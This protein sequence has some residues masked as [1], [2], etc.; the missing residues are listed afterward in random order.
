VASTTFDLMSGLQVS[1]ADS[2][3]SVPVLP[4]TASRSPGHR[5]SLTDAILSSKWRLADVDLDFAFGRRFSRNAPQITIWGVSATRSLTPQLALVAGAGRSGSD[6][7]TSVPGSRYFVLGLRLKVG[8]APSGSLVAPPPPAEHTPFRIGPALP[9]GREVLVRA[10]AARQVE[11]AGDFTDWKPVTLER[12]D[13]GA[14]RAV[15]PIAPGVHRLAIRIDQG[16]WRA[17][18]GSRPVPNEF[19]GE[20]AEIVVE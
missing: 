4:A 19:G 1:R 3:E 13:R 2:A 11:L 15:L 8:A 17:P 5:R 14:W 20:V 10:P 6:P 18:P 7:V 16:E 12:S 9:A